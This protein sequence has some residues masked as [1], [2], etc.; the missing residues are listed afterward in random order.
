[1]GDI[2]GDDI[3]AAALID[4]AREPK[5]APIELMEAPCERLDVGATSRASE[6]DQELAAVGARHRPA[7]R[8]R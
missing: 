8:N 2:F 6:G 5:S 1:M 4:R 7:K 3:M